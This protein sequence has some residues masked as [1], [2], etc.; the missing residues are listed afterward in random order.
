VITFTQAAAFT[1]RLRNDDLA[2]TRECCYHAGK[3]CLPAACVNQHQ[4]KGWKGSTIR[5]PRPEEWARVR[6]LGIIHY[7]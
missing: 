1:H 7:G 3:Y 5:P 6:G 4:Q 2:S